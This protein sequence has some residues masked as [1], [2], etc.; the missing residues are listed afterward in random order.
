M[1]LNLLLVCIVIG[2]STIEVEACVN[3]SS[4]CLIISSLFSCFLIPANGL[5]VVSRLEESEELEESEFDE[6]DFLKFRKEPETSWKI[7]FVKVHKVTKV[8]YATIPQL[9]NKLSPESPWQ[10][11]SPAIP[12]VVQTCTHG[13]TKICVSSVDFMQFK[14]SWKCLLE[15]CVPL[16]ENKK[17]QRST[18][19][20]AE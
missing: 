19:C 4:A 2:F 5:F 7:F 12:P 16:P 13:T 6:K 15:M 9:N 1:A 14:N 17:T 20:P 11:Y 3:S 8:R 18:W 10:P